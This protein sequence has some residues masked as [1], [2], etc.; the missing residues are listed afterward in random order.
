MKRRS[1][2]V[3]FFMIL[4]FMS[5]LTIMV[6]VKGASN[7]DASVSR[8]L[9]DGTNFSASNLDET[10]SPSVV[11]G[12]AA[13]NLEMHASPMRALMVNTR[14]THKCYLLIKLS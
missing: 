5:S 3:I 6:K 7:V 8:S 4:I 14:F 2:K 11:E 13:S 1:L 10:I 9:N 12:S